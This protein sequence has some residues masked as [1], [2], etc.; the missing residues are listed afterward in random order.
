MSILSYIASI[1]PDKIILFKDCKNWSPTFQAIVY[2][3]LSE[4]GYTDIAPVSIDKENVQLTVTKNSQTIVVY[5][6]DEFCAANIL[7]AVN[8]GAGR[9]VQKY[10]RRGSKIIKLKK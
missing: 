7:E 2:N 8:S 10:T 1:N 4:A 3:C 9:Y 5:L 6:I